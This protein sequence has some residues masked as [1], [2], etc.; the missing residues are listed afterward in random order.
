MAS[1][2]KA[3]RRRREIKGWDQAKLA[4]ECGL[5][6]SYISKVEKDVH[7][8]S[9]RHLIAI[10]DALGARLI[11]I[12]MDAQAVEDAGEDTWRRELLSVVDLLP[13]SDRGELLRH[14]ELL[15]RVMMDKRR[16]RENDSPGRLLPAVGNLFAGACMAG[17]A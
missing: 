10:A 12:L 4:A 11:D 16:Q 17:A 7:D 3:V 8:P 15:A 5:S 2:G 9:W 13:E 1:L 14:I 6:Q